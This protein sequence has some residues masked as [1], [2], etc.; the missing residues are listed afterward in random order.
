[1]EEDVV[2]VHLSVHR[3]KP[4][5]EQDLIDS[6]H[7]FGR[8]DGGPFPGL[9]EALTLR[10]RET[11]TLVGITMWDSEE[12]FRASVDR[13]RAAVQDDDFD[14]WEDAPPDVYVLDPV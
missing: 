3:P 2:L 1:L 12:A 8:G 10:D 14:A 13:M 11:G 9:R 7:R 5:R 4:G 6:M